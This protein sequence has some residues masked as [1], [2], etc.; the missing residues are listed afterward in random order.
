MIQALLG[1]G[2][3]VH[4]VTVLGW[5]PLHDASN[6]GHADAVTLLLDHGANVNIENDEG[7]TALHEAARQDHSD[8]VSVLLEHGACGGGGAAQCSRRTRAPSPHA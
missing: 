6:E 3:D 7:D 5:T 1:F 4:A 8:C 2:A